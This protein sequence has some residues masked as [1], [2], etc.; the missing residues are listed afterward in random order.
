MNPL[1]FTIIESFDSKQLFFITFA[2]SFVFE[3]IRMEVIKLS[4]LS[5]VWN[6]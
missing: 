4:D 1:F 3:I 2:V 5:S 6:V